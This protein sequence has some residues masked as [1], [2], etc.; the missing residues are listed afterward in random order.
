MASPILLKALERKAEQP[1]LDLQS[2]LDLD[3]F[4]QANLALLQ[5]VMPH[6]SC[7]LMLGIVDDSPAESRHHV[8]TDPREDYLPASSLSVSNPYLISHPQIK[9]YTYSDIVRADPRASLRRREQEPQPGDWNQFV[10][11]AF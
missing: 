11:L 6:H 7:S 8:A 3:S 5:C 10:H 2:A 1:L 9:I 4:W